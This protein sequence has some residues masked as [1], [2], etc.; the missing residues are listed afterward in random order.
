MRHDCHAT[1][2]R[3]D[4]GQQLLNPQLLYGSLTRTGDVGHMQQRES[5]AVALASGGVRGGGAR[6]AKAAA[7]GIHADDEQLVRVQRLARTNLLL[8]PAGSAA[9]AMASGVRADGK[10][11]KN[12]HGIVAGRVELAPSLHRDHGPYQFATALQPERRGQRKAA[13]GTCG[14][15]GSGGECC[16]GTHA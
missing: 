13:R 5:G 2:R 7:Q 1:E 4:H 16:R 3:T 12:Q 15:T 10:T 9:V 14:Q 11:G 8:P 6:A